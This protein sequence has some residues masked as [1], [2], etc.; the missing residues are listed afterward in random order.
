MKQSEFWRAAARLAE[1]A[2]DRG[3]GNDWVKLVDGERLFDLMAD[4]AERI[5]KSKT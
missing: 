5:E 3:S 1:A 2:K 4:E